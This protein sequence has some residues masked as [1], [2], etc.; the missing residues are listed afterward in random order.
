MNNPQKM[1]LMQLHLK[2][3]NQLLS[4]HRILAKI[5]CKHAVISIENDIETNGITSNFRPSLNRLSYSQE[6]KL[7]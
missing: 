1:E 3:S 5:H 6:E 7:T 2:I 4:F